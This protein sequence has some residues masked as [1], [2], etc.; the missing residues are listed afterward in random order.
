[1]SAHAGGG[2]RDTEGLMS[3]AAFFDRLRSERPRAPEAFDRELQEK[4]TRELSI[5]MADSS[6]FTRLTKEYGILAFLSAMR[7]AYDLIVPLIEA[8]GVVLSQNADNVLAVFARPEDA[9]VSAAEMHRALAA[10]NAGLHPGD[11]F[12]VCIGI[13]HGPVIRLTDNVYGDHVNIA[14]KVGEDL[15]GLGEILVTAAVHERLDPKFQRG[16]SRSA[17]L[18]GVPIEIYRVDY[19]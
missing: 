5:L 19:D 16:Y 12:H 2:L 8:R 14:A 6:G 11:H 17:D 1:M 7:R 15:A 13:D 18:G 4:H 3:S 10:R 9:V